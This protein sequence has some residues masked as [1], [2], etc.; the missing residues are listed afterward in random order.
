MIIFLTITSLILL[1]IS[2]LLLWQLL[3]QR[4]MI[5]NML[6]NEDISDIH[7]EPEL[8]LTLRVLD[9]IALAKRESR[10]G[11][12]L[13]DKLPVMTRKMVYQE[14][15]KELESELFERDIDVEMHIEYR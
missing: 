10:T 3:E 8:V 9:P 4:K 13:A 6:E 14:V 15:M 11:R 7:R 12:A 1:A 5:N 2:G